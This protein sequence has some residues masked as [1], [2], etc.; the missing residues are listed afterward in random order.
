MSASITGADA[1]THLKIVVTALSAS[2]VILWVAIAGRLESYVPRP[3]GARE[4]AHVVLTELETSS[5]E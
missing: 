3:D 5:G 1:R 4:A 2:M